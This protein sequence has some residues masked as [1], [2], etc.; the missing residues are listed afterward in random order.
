MPG[1]F[2]TF[3]AKIYHPPETVL[4]K[5]VNPVRLCRILTKVS[6]NYINHWN[7]KIK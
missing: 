6:K 3:Q 1:D 5:V 2:I 4:M 7:Q